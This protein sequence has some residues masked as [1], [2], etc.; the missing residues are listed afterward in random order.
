ML[1]KSDYGFA[2]RTSFMPIWKSK[3]PLRL[4]LPFIR[5]QVDK[6]TEIILEDARQP[7][8]AV[9]NFKTTDGYGAKFT[10]NCLKSS[11]KIKSRDSGYGTIWLS[12]AFMVLQYILPLLLEWWVSRKETESE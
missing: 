4:R 9:V 12:L 3:M 8:A 6:I 5:R 7:L 10:K 2:V 11:L 1:S